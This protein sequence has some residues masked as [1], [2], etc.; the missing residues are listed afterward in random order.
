M[1]A[2]ASVAQAKFLDGVGRDDMGHLLDIV[3]E[4]NQMLVFGRN[5]A[6]FKHAGVE[7]VQD[8]CPIVFPHQDDRE[9]LDLAGLNQGE[10]LEEFV[11]RAETAGHDHECVGV[12]DQHD[13]SH[14]EIAKVQGGIE[15]GILALLKGQPDPTAHR[16]A[17]DVLGP[18]V[19]GFHDA[20]AAT[21]HDG[22]PKFSNLGGR[23]AGELIIAMVF[24]KARGAK[25]SDAGA[26]KMKFAKAL[27]K[28]PTYAKKPHKLEAA[29][30]GA[31]QKTNLLL[32]GVD[33]ESGGFGGVL[34]DTSLGEK[35][36]ARLC[37]TTSTDTTLGV[38]SPLL[39]L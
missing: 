7:R 22:Q 31:L 17:A 38:S 15:V 18:A 26:D 11:H 39:R 5:R 35:G 32:G 30:G 6:G 34:H 21:G 20:R 3:G 2:W 27:Q 23:I 8:G 36:E 10:G 16:F 19:G 4:E 13:L 24:V 28:L 29:R 25:N 12:F 1:G 33:N 14:E 37:G 9:I